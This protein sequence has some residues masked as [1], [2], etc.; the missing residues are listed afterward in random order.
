MSNQNNLQCCASWF[1]RKKTSNLGEF[2]SD[3]ARELG[4]KAFDGEKERKLRATV[5]KQLPGVGYIYMGQLFIQF[6]VGKITLGIEN[7]RLEKP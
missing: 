7:W 4:I 5:E 2:L 6:S 3:V 1:G